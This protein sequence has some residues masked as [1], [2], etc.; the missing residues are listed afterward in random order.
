MEDTEEFLETI[1]RQDFPS[2]I[3]KVFST[4]NPGAKYHANWHIDLI[5]EYLEGVRLGQIKRLI[6][7][8]PPRTLKSVCVSV[9]WPAW[10]LSLNPGARIMVASYSSILNVSL[11]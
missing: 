2:F 9:A 6:I 7:N 10:L 1:L 3:G 8:M 11:G 4:I 5:A